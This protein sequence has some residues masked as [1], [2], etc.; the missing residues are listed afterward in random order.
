[1][2]MTNVGKISASGRSTQNYPLF[3]KQEVQI[4][5]QSRLETPVKVLSAGILQENWLSFSNY[6]RA[7]SITLQINI[8]KIAN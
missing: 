8:K 7:T 3:I 2:K 1:M 6:E 5:R 4:L